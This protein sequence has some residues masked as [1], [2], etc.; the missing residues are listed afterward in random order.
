MHSVLLVYRFSSR[1]PPGPP[2]GAP[3]VDSHVGRQAA[4]HH[5]QVKPVALQLDAL[6][7]HVAGLP[8]QLALHLPHPPH[9]VVGHIAAGLG[10]QV[11]PAGGRE[12][13][14]GL[15][16]WNKGRCHFTKQGERFLSAATNSLVFY[17]DPQTS[18]C[19]ALLCHCDEKETVSLFTATCISF[20]H[21]RE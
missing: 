8:A 17:Y 21:S 15:G 9:V 14:L 7:R 18:C 19:A 13:H 11:P 3:L 12:G 20:S 1:R 16:L 10:A 4:Q 6:L 2:P 5:L